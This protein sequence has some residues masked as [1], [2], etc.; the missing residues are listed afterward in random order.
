[1]AETLMSTTPSCFALS[2]GN[3]ITPASMSIFRHAAC[4]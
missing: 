3:L 2:M 1:M 4:P